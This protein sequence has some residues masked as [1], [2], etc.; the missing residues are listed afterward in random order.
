MRTLTAEELKK[1][2]E[3]NGTC[4]DRYEY[5]D[6]IAEICNG[7]VGSITWWVNA[8]KG[9]VLDENTVLD[10]ATKTVKGV[11]KIWAIT[12]VGTNKGELKGYYT[13]KATK[14]LA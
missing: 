9:V 13:D 3:I 6:R 1:I 14:Q 7:Y 12:I 10:I 2:N 8:V 4:A 11:K 5:F